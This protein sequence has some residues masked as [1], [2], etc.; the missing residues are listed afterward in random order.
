MPPAVDP[1]ANRYD[2]V[3]IVLTNE[4][5]T[6]I[7]DKLVPL[8]SFISQS[9]VDNGELTLQGVP[10]NLSSVASTLS[11]SGFTLS[12]SGENDESTITA[13][14][15]PSAPKSISLPKRPA[16]SKLQKAAIWSYSDPSTPT[17]DPSSLLQPSDLV[18]PIPTCEPAVAG[19]PRRKK[20]CKGCTC[21]LAEL[22]AT[23][24]KDAKVVV[25]SGVVD[26]EA[27]AVTQDEKQRL[28]EAAAKAS[29]ATSSCGSCFLGDAFRCASC[30]YLGLPAFKPGEKV[31]IDV[32]MDDI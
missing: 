27:I 26:G 29:K 11:T 17:L 10:R 18:R 21:G 23:E 9:L 7:G 3:Y 1:I 30:P 19:A 32:G 2:K 4:D 24:A 8:L 5:Y 16:A 12:Q 14:K 15:K 25:L 20:A 6:S 13:H 28:V 31:V 22:E